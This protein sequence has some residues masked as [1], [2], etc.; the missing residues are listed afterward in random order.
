M[1][2]RVVKVVGV[3]RKSGG[4]GAELFAFSVPFRL[5]KTAGVQLGWLLIATIVLLGSTLNFI[6]APRGFFFY[7]RDHLGSMAALGIGAR[8]G[9]IISSN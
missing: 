8:V 2:D 1:N 3:G 9:L 6:D 7:N 5:Y 4:A